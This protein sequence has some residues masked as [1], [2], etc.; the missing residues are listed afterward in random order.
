MSD[1]F[2]T[3]VSKVTSDDQQASSRRS[4]QLSWIPLITQIDDSFT[5]EVGYIDQPSSTACT[6]TSLSTLPEGYTSFIN[7]TDSSVLVTGLNSGTCYLF[8]VRVYSSRTPIPGGWTL[9][10]YQ[11]DI[12]GIFIFFI[13]IVTFVAFFNLI[14][15]TDSVKCSYISLVGGTVSGYVLSAILLVALV[16][17]NVWILKR[18]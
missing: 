3:A 5:Y 17:Q 14:V 16:I 11:T 7:I 2:F 10:L 9:L 12:T 6:R 4:V 13:L 18:R 15:D 1:L 8:G